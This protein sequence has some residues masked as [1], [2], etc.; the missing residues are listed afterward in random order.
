MFAYIVVFVV[1]MHDT[2]VK[3]IK[4]VLD[5]VATAPTAPSDAHVDKNVA[6][7]PHTI[8]SLDGVESKENI[9]QQNLNPGL[10]WCTWC[11]S[12]AE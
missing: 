4:T 9:N 12:S 8:N 3:I 10:G 5:S 1:S 6:L 2:T 7:E 11:W